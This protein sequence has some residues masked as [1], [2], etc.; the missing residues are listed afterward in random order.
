M[1][2][3]ALIFA[4]GVGKRMDNGALPKQF[5]EIEG[6]PIIIYTLEVFEKNKN[7]DG[8]VV[9]IT[10]GW[11]DY[12]SNLVR[13]FDLKK[14]LKIVEGGET[15]QLSQLHALNAMKDF[16][17]DQTVVLIHD[18]VRPLIN[19]DV[20]DKNI[21]SVK[22]NGSGVTVKKAI[23]TVV[24]VDGQGQEISK[25]LDRDKY[26]MAVAPQ[27]YYFKDIYSQHLEANKKGMINFI[28]SA[29]LM[30]FFGHKLFF[31]EGTTDNIK[32]TTPVDYYIFKGILEA[33]KINQIF[34]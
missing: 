9:S 2:N 20:I 18:G 21:D 5:L 11:V 23:E 25:V 10:P 12:L 22:K 3:I 31:I 26:R 16:V 24:L 4:G 1:K 27:S 6:K 28:D 15:S 33:K 32:I 34:K 14:V 17:T 19:D 8:V 13:R 7:I 29:Q 30:Q